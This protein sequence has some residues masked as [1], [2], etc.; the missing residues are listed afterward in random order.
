[1]KSNHLFALIVVLLVLISAV[2]A[3][4]LSPEKTTLYT[5]YYELK[6]GGAE[7]QKVAYE[8]A[9]EYLQKFGGDTDQYTEAVRKFVVAYERASREVEF[10]KAYNAKD[11]PKTFDVG[12]QILSSEPENFLIL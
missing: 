7:G 5:K 12:R 1:M 6:K 10:Y 9:K 8:V 11:Y 2:Y 4:E 3:Q